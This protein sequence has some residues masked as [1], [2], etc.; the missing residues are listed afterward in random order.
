MNDD[1]RFPGCQSGSPHPDSGAL[2]Q[3]DWAQQ[4]PLPS[5]RPATGALEEPAS[6]LPEFPPL[7]GPLASPSCSF[8]RRENPFSEPSLCH[9]GT[10]AEGHGRSPQPCSRPSF[11]LTLA[12]VDRPHGWQSRNQKG[13]ACDRCFPRSLLWGQGRE[14]WGSSGRRRRVEGPERSSLGLP[15]EGWSSGQD[16]FSRLVLFI[17]HVF[18]VCTCDQRLPRW[19]S[20]KE[21]A[22]QCRRLRKHRF[23]P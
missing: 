20:G 11:P 19:L 12:G 10:G 14:R 21:S 9:R 2:F 22:C 17:S 13:R 23:H 6:Y 15:P 5:L 4:T 7:L 3:A 1:T 16:R 8:T 18:S